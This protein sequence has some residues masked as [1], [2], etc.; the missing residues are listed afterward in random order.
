MKKIVTPLLLIISF[1]SF[2]Q[3]ASYYTNKNFLKILNK[4]TTY[5][6]LRNKITQEYIHSNPGSWGEFVKDVDEDIKTTDKIIAFTFDACGKE[7]GTGFDKELID[8]LKRESIPATLF[9]TGRWIDD[10][11]DTFKE[12]ASEKLFEIENHGLNHQ[13]CS[14]DGESEYG[15]HGTATVGDAFDEI[16]ANVRKIAAIT[17]HKPHFYRS[18][19]AFI[20]EACAKMARKLNVQAIS[21]QV[22]SGDAVPFTPINEIED[23]VLKNV[24]PGAI[25]IMHMNH[26]QWNTFEALERLVPKLRAEGYRFVQIKDFPL[27]SV[28]GQE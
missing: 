27:Y 7:K 17:G 20:D 9:I 19:T 21:F 22:L 3:E 28:K 11:F 18:A 13:P 15:I 10:H 8:Y 12:L 14:I 1:V 2:A 24:K 6:A 23:N 26:P 5:V 25:V 16:E 4:D